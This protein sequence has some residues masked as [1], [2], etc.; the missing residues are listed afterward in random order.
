MAKR[1]DKDRVATLVAGH[2]ANP[3]RPA[4]PL[5]GS[6]L[7]R[8]RLPGGGELS[9]DLATWLAF[10]A[11]W[12]P[13]LRGRAKP[14]WALAEAAALRP[15]LPALGLPRDVPLVALE[16]AAS[17]EHYLAL[18]PGRGNPVLAWDHAEVTVAAAS[19]ADY[20]ENHYPPRPPSPGRPRGPAVGRVVAPPPAEVAKLPVEALE[21]LA[22]GLCEKRNAKLLKQVALVAAVVVALAQH[23]AHSTALVVL[24]AH[25]AAWRGGAPVGVLVPLLQIAAASGDPA[26]ARWAL[27]VYCA[28]AKRDPDDLYFTGQAHA[29]ALACADVVQERELA[30]QVIEEVFSFAGDVPRSV[31]VAAP[32]LADLWKRPSMARFAARVQALAVEQSTQEAGQAR[33]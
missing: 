18:L 22:R 15:C 19:F 28:V 4:R 8:L 33:G 20:L 32:E 30:S 2:A 23:R 21:T 27:D 24:R 29:L 9:D 31:P 14:E 16:P 25:A 11:S 1:T 13:L 17:E 5:R 6:L 7:E 12:L 3:T 26:A 10:D